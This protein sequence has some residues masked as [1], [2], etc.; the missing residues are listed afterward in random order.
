[1]IIFLQPYANASGARNIVATNASSVVFVYITTRVR[2]VSLVTTAENNY[3][4]VKHGQSCSPG[5]IPY[6]KYYISV[7][8]RPLSV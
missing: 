8:G 6:L 4:H 7:V 5:R 3:W 1:M 2:C